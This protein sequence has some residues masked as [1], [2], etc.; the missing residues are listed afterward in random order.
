VYAVRPTRAYGF[1]K[2]PYS[3]TRWTFEP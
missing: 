1:G 3:H 2:A